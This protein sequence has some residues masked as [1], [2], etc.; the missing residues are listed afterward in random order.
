MLVLVMVVMAVIVRN[1]VNA[2]LVMLVM[3]LY[4]RVATVT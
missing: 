4:S 3:V 1:Y 2:V